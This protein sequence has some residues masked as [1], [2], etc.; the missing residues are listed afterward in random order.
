MMRHRGMLAWLSLAVILLI[1]LSALD[2]IVFMVRQ[3]RGETF[4]FVNVRQYVAV[5]DRHGNF[6][7]AYLGQVDI[8]CVSA[9]LPHQH[10]TPCWW[11]AL[12]SAHYE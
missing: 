11:V 10:T 2:Y 1:G 6:H 9:L 7:S 5:S 4:A 12:H 8:P 3:R